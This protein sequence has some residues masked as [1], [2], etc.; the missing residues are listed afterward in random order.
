[1]VNS[2]EYGLLNALLNVQSYAQLPQAEAAG[3]DCQD[4]GF[5]QYLAAARAVEGVPEEQFIDY[6]GWNRY[7]YATKEMAEW[8]AGRLGG[9]VGT[10]HFDWSPPFEPPP[11]GYTVRFG[12]KEIN[13][14]ALAIYFEPGRFM[15]QDEEAALALFR[16]GVV[17]AYVMQHR[18]ELL[19]EFGIPA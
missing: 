18:P 17:N 12:D 9:E 5:G 3:P 2:V 8:L 4:S 19:E 16:D 11:D 1:M 15:G 10:F 13:A 7:N 14:G 6:P